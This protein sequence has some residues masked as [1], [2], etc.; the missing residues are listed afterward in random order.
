LMPLL[1]IGINVLV[2]GGVIWAVGNVM[3][4]RRRS[5]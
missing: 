3:E 2:W 5:T 1:I 4:S